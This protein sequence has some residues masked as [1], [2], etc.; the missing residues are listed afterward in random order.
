MATSTK[1]LQTFRFRPRLAADLLREVLHAALPAFEGVRVEG[2]DGGSPEEGAPVVVVLTRARTPV[3]GIV[4]EAPES[5]ENGDRMTWPQHARHVASR[6]GAEADVLV[7][8]SDLVV[9]RWAKQPVH[10]PE[11]AFA[12]N[13]LGP[14]SL[15][16]DTPQTTPVLVLMT[17]ASLVTRDA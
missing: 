9:E 15:S 17:L 7:V 6:I 14:S 11:G 1:I 10:L 2:L 3:R 8:T 5:C 4:V 13:V 12:P 16:S